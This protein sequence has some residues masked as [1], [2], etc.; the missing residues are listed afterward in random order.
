[1]YND[2]FYFHFPLNFFFSVEF[3]KVDVQSTCQFIISLMTGLNLIEKHANFS[4]SLMC[5]HHQYVTA[6]AIACF[7]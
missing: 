1:M 6:S 7:K 3:D 2:M 4:H 5:H